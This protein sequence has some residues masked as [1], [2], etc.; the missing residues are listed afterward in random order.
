MSKEQKSVT[1][2]DIKWAALLWYIHLHFFGVYGIWLILTAAKW[3]TVFFTIFIT[4]LGYLGV[5]AGAHR[6]WAHRTYEASW[7]LRL[8]LMLAHT[9]T[10]VGPIYDWVLMHRLHHKYYGTD[11]DPYNHKKGFLYSHYVANFLSWDA[12]VKE[13]EVE[14][15][16]RDMQLDNFV[17]FQKLFYWPLFII[18]GVIL[19]LNA[20]LEYWDE[21]MTVSVITGLLRFA[22]LVNISWLVNSGRIIWSAEGKKIPADDLSIFFVKRTFW[23]AYHYMVPWDWKCGEFGGY[24]NGFTNTFIKLSYEFGLVKNQLTSNSEDIREM[25]D[26][27]AKKKSTLKNGL[28]KLK[29]I[30]VYNAKKQQLEV[31]M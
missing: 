5:T 25:L 21:S 8:L 10:G 7:S 2:Q 31:Q 29:E 13:M 14:V 1:I 17:Y 12:Y 23:Q 6:L 20:P 11:K 26:Q 16:M 28:A 4:I 15:D 9:L 19:P 24:G 3:K 27:L 18:F 30:S 22:I